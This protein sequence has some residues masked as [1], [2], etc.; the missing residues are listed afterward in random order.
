MVSSLAQVAVAVAVGF[1]AG[2]IPF[3]Y[4]AG[5]LLK[6]QDIRLLGDGNVG[7][8]NAYRELGPKIGIAV[9][10]ADIAKGALVV[11]L[12]HRIG[13][14]EGAVLSSGAAVVAGHNWPLVLQFK[15][16]RGAAT[17][18]GVLLVALFPASLISFAACAAAA[19]A[20][21][22]STA[23]CAAMFA[24]LPFIALMLGYPVHLIL[25]A[26][27]LP[28]VVSI[29]HF[30]QVVLPHYQRTGRLSLSARE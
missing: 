5:R 21:R 16:G 23:A 30:Y 20:R 2:S 14:A 19:L 27:G 24:P 12:F 3:A 7:A 8:E 10:F 11:A 18:V 28:V 17:T 6:G 9:G 13:F 29:I 25:Y 1:A 15:G 4:L 22:G 26:I